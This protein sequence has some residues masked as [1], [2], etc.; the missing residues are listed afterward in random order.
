MPADILHITSE[1]NWEQA[2]VEDVY[3][4]DTLATE[5]FIH[6]CTPEQ[7]AGV[8]DRYFRGRMN[9]VVLRIDREKLEPPLE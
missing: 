7:I 9:L 6:C 3:R 4:G 5:G 2:V 8:R 1:E